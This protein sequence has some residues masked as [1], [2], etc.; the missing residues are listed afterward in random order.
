MVRVI[1]LILY[2]FEYFGFRV[3]LLYESLDVA[4]AKQKCVLDQ[5][6]AEKACHLPMVER[7]LVLIQ[8]REYRAKLQ[9]ALAHVAKLEKLA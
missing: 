1:D 3:F 5:F 6:L 9:V 2:V 4:F 8:L 7:F